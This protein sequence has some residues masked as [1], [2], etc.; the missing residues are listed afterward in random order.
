MQKRV[1][2]SI[3][4]SIVLIGGAV[5]TRPSNARNTNPELIGVYN[6]AGEME[7]YDI[8]DFLTSN[9][10]S[11]T[12]LTKTDMVGRQLISDYLNLTTSGKATE[13]NINSLINQHIESISHL[14][15]KIVFDRSDLQTIEDSKANFQKYND[16]VTKIEEERQT[17]VK[18]VYAK[19]TNVSTLNADTFFLTDSIGLA[20]ETAAQKL[21]KVPTPLSLASIHTQ[22]INNF[23]STA[24]GMRSISKVDEDPVAT[25]SSMVTVNNNTKEERVLLGQIITILKNNNVQ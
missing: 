23:L 3:V 10:A 19:T 11:T 9:T 5:W 2:L 15:E 12:P 14:N 1:I 13:S 4:L 18:S 22:L 17:K 21:M 7:I 24:S 6:E 8:T 16:I 20:Y 25:L